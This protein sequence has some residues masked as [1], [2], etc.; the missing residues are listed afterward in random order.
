M[1]ASNCDLVNY[2]ELDVSSSIGVPLR[3]DITVEDAA[4]GINAAFHH[5]NPLFYANFF[6]TGGTTVEEINRGD[7]FSGIQVCA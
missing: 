1:Q 5:D 4:N 7:L 6:R 3:S 2:P